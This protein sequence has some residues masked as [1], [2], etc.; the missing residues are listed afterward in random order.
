MFRGKV[1][2]LSELIV[3][4]LLPVGTGAR[5][6]VIELRAA[7]CECARG[8]LD[9]AK[10]SGRLIYWPADRLKAFDHFSAGPPMEAGRASGSERAQCHCQ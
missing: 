8:F 3:L 7:G 5:R 10:L 1:V 4:G 9:G 2:D 6:S